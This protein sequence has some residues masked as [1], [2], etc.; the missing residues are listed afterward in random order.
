VLGGAVC[1]CKPNFVVPK[2]GAAHSSETLEHNYPTWHKILNDHNQKI[3][4]HMSG[5]TVHRI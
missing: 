1:V 3:P 4:Y 2:M 5:T